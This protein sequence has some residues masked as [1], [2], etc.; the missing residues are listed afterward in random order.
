[1]KFPPFFVIRVIT[2][3]KKGV[4]MELM[5]E[6]LVDLPAWV[7]IAICVGTFG[8]G[9]TFAYILDRTLPKRP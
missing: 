7:K 4:F 6:I 8:M 1:V 5:N 9:L 3:F 2:T